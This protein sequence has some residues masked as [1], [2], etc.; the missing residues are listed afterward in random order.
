MQSVLGF[1]HGK[2]NRTNDDGNE[3]TSKEENTK[4]S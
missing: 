4:K 3:E 2:D 1:L